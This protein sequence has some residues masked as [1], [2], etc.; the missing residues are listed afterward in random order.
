M[1]VDIVGGRVPVVVVVDQHW[2]GSRDLVV[3]IWHGVNGGGVVAIVVAVVH[4]ELRRGDGLHKLSDKFV[5]TFGQ[6]R[7]VV[8]H[9]WWWWVGVVG[10]IVKG[11]HGV[12]GHQCWS[13]SSL[14]LG[15]GGG[16]IVVEV[17]TGGVMV[18]V[19]GAI[20]VDAGGGVAGHWR[21]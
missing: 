20:I 8:S 2:G 15:C 12:A 17:D 19:G 5:I 3:V 13:S 11:G 10:R 14:A 6:W 16:G 4:S 9:W 21:W 7:W 18:V 1:V